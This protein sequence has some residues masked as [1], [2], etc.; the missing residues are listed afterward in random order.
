MATDEEVGGKPCGRN[1]HCPLCQQLKDWRKL[2]IFTHGLKIDLGKLP[3]SLVVFCEIRR[4]NQRA[5]C[6]A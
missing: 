3:N 4:H 1:L 2:D 6:R 5:L